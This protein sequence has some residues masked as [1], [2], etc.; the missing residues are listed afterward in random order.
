MLL[1]ELTRGETHHLGEGLAHPQI[2]ER[3]VVRCV[4]VLLI[5]E[6]LDLDDAA[7]VRGGARLDGP[8][9]GFDLVGALGTP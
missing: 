3:I 4:D 5:G 1:L 2:V 9:V 8:E 7:T 6:K